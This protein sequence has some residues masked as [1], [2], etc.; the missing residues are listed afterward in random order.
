MTGASLIAA[1]RGGAAGVSVLRGGPGD[2][3]RA[4]GQALARR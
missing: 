2:W 1:A 3:A 4:T